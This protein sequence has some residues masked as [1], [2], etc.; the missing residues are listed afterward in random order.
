MELNKICPP[1]GRNDLCLCFLLHPSMPPHPLSMQML[2]YLS[3]LLP[4]SYSIIKDRRKRGYAGSSASAKTV[5][6]FWGGGTPYPTNL[7]SFSCNMY[8]LPFLI[9][10]LLVYG[11]IFGFFLCD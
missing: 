1:N 4:F 7:N 3:P 8:D 11:F 5:F 6:F 9:F 2:S 10:L